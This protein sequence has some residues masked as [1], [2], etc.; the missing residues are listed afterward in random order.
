MKRLLLLAALAASSLAAQDQKKQEPATAPGPGAVQK[1]IV[2]KYADA[3][4]VAD[5]L[6]VFNAVIMPNTEMHAIAVTAQAPQMTAIEDAVARLDTPAAAPKNFE[7]TCYLLIGSETDGNTGPL[8]K[9]LESVVTQL[10]NN[11]PFKVYRVMDV[12]N[13]RAR[14]GQSLNT[15]SNGA[16]FSGP[17]PDVLTTFHINSATLA[18]DGSTIRID[19][20]WTNSRIPVGTPER[21]NYRDLGLNTDV[22]IK[23]GQKVVI[24]RVGIARDQAL[25]LVLTAKVVN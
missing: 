9:E 19:G 7:L 13:M 10:K 20:L 16:M 23:E 6:R 17:G 12:L 1:L 2:L 5:L 25:F 18:P 22:D 14:T 24:G 3:R 15:S 4:A 21:F 8:P 11:F